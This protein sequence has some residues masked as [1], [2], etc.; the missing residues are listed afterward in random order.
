MVGRYE[1]PTK[2]PDPATAQR[3]RQAILAGHQAPNTSADTARTLLADPQAPVRAAALNALHRLNQ[4]TGPQ[5][6]TGLNDPTAAVQQQA[7]NVATQQLPTKELAQEVAQL[8]DHHDPNVIETTC[9]ALGEI[10]PEL[11]QPELSEQHATQLA[12]LGQN[13]DDPLCREAAIAAL[14]ALGHPNSLQVILAALND[15]PPIRR[16][17]TLALA[18]YQGP[19]VDAAL[20]RMLTDRD[21]QTR[22]AAEDL[23]SSPLNDPPDEDETP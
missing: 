15:K 19:Q 16:R 2:P 5:L 22:Q 6:T 3:R 9:W 17:A 8:L 1:H 4:L 14:G 12:D 7:L 23:T 21:P 10:L 18:P 20:K 13:H 11:N